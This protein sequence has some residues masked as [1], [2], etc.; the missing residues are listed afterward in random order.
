MQLASSWSSSTL[1]F[2]CGSLHG[3]QQQL[4]YYGVQHWLLLLRR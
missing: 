3:P 1:E 2:F 4:P